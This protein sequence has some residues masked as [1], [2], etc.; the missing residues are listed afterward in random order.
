MKGMYLP[1]M[2]ELHQKVAA[3]LQNDFIPQQQRS[4]KF[5][6]LEKLKTIS[7][8]IINFLSVPKGDITPA[9]KD[10]VGYNEKKIIVFLNLHWPRA[11][12]RS[13]S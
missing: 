4:D 12:P 9:L 11:A 3:K 7:E 2:T 10:K 5:E 13:L 8:R 6:K 1:D